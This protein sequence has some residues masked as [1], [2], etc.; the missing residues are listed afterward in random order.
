[1]IEEWKEINGFEGKYW[2]S[3]LGRVRGI[4]STLKLKPKDTGYTQVNLYKSSKYI[5]K[6]IHRLV[7]EAFIPNPDNLPQIDHIDGNRENNCVTNLRWCTPS[8]NNRNPVTTHRKRV[9]NMGSNNPMYGKP[10]SMRGVTKS[11]HFN[12]K[13]VIRCSISGDSLE[14]YGSLIEAGEAVNASPSTISNCIAGR[15]KSCKGYLW[16]W[17]M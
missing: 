3:N 5:T 4:K 14:E 7:A 1:M 2:I 8:E 15:L 9:V 16:R 6:L 11:N 12:S 17:K 13:K 10:S